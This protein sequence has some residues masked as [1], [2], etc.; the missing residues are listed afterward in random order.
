MFLPKFLRHTHIKYIIHINFR[1]C[2]FILYLVPILLPCLWGQD[3]LLPWPCS[4]QW[5]NM[6]AVFPDGLNNT[7]LVWSPSSSISQVS[8]WPFLYPLVNR[9]GVSFDCVSKTPNSDGSSQGI[10]S[11]SLYNHFII[12]HEYQ[13]AMGCS[14]CACRLCLIW[15]INTPLVFACFTCKV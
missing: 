6:P 11:T 2:D 7:I 14:G 5:K 15:K 8:S 3:L 13:C 9:A 4:L 10:C 12:S 1:K